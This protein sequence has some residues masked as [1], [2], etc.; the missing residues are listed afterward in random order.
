MA[1]CASIWNVANRVE[2]KY[3]DN[4]MVLTLSHSSDQ[5]VSSGLA[6]RVFILFFNSVNCVA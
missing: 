5:S 2:W 3:A 4:I 6:F 1:V